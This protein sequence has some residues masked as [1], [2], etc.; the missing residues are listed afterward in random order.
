MVIENPFHNTVVRVRPRHA[1]N[2]LIL[3]AR[4]WDRVSRALCGV[5]DCCCGMHQWV[6][7]GI[8]ATNYTICTRIDGSVAIRLD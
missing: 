1:G 4:T 7:D 5:T 3:S 2:W 8:P 6:I